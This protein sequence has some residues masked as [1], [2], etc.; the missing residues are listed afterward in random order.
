MYNIQM[1]STLPK[2]I[3][4]VDDIQNL[5]AKDMLGS[6]FNHQIKPNKIKGYPLITHVL[7]YLKGKLYLEA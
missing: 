3:V 1:Q 6:T 7:I 5:H 2:S 4:Y